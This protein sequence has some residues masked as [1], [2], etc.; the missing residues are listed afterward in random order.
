MLCAYKVGFDLAQEI[1]S[2][3][4]VDLL[5]HDC[6]ALLLR[7]TTLLFCTMIVLHYCVARPDR[8]HP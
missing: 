7:F 1:S 5:L 2:R 8:A 4:Q 3:A 6:D